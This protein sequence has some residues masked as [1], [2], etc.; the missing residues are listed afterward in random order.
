MKK[1]SV[2]LLSFCLSLSAY[3]EEADVFAA[4][5]TE[6]FSIPAIEA[7][8]FPKVDNAAA[9]T[10]T[11][12]AADVAVT[13]KQQDEELTNAVFQ[14][15]SVPKLQSAIALIYDEQGKR[16]LYT[17]NAENI[18]PIASITKLMTA[19]VILDAK[20]PMDE[21]ITIC[22]D[23]ADHRKGTRSRMRPGLTL[24]R[25]ELLKL[26]LMASENRAAAALARTYPG[27]MDAA[28]ARMNAKAQELGMHSTR[29]FDPT[30]LNSNNVST[31]QDL[32]LMVRAAQYYE[33]IHQF[34]TSTSHTVLYPKHR[35]LRFGNTNPLVKNASWDIGISKTG[36]IS[37]AGRCLVM[38]ATISK[39]P[40]IIVLLDSW[41]KRTRVGDANRI[42]KWMESASGRVARSGRG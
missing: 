14:F 29:F 13:P 32:V 31:A 16:P 34:T 24:S 17:K 23:D 10:V 19:M 8:F 42:K 3:A 38:K 25:G 30:G 26:A 5:K 12:T 35:P 28:V 20:L 4:P 18:A 22:N 9:P 37:E 33:P 1:I 40:V 27:G 21:K 36:Y 7:F 15:T 11:T 6:L 41:G 39:R 2:I